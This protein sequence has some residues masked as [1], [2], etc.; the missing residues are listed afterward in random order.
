MSPTL[1]QPIHYGW[2]SF[3]EKLSANIINLVNSSATTATWALTRHEIYGGFKGLD[4]SEIMSDFQCLSKFKNMAMYWSH[5]CC[6]LWNLKTVRRG[7]CGSF[8][9]WLSTSCSQI[10]IKKSSNIMTTYLIQNDEVFIFLSMLIWMRK[11]V[12]WWFFSDDLRARG[13]ESEKKGTTNSAPYCFSNFMNNN[14]N[15]KLFINCTLK[16]KFLSSLMRL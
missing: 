2:C 12:I 13:Q 5:D 7:I 1:P 6:D 9:L 10:I 14:K 8:F 16:I 15:K 3:S 11:V 4:F